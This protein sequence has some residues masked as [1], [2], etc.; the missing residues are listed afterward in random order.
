M[1]I[2][3]IPIWE[4]YGLTS[5]QYEDLVRPY[6]VLITELLKSQPAKVLIDLEVHKMD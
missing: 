5:A 6:K 1:E 2:R 4:T 3:E